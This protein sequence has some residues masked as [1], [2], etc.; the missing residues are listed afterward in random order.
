MTWPFAAGAIVS[1]VNDLAKW[2]AALDS[3]RLLKPSS[4]QQMWTPVK[5]NDGSPYPY[6]FGWSVDQ[7]KG[8]TC[9]SHSGGIPGFTSYIARFPADHL[10]VIV[11]CNQ[12]VDT[13]KIANN[14]AGFYIH[15]LA[16][17]T[18]EPIEDKEPQVTAKVK[19]IVQQ[20]ADGKVDSTLFTPDL[21][22]T[23][24]V[25]L[26]R[27]GAESLHRFGAVQSITLVERTN[28]GNNRIYR[29]HLVYKDMTLMM[30]C[31]FNRDNKIAGMT[32]QPE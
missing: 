23:M 10:A 25:D 19:M 5:L 20:A 28:E 30:V 12:L 3:D 26:K 8:H 32:L 29:Y 4:L 6:G 18:Y 13:G 21:A 24:A 14:V 31:T 9:I 17:P 11:L 1:T 16:P 22:T 27:G 15:A 2:D 7:V